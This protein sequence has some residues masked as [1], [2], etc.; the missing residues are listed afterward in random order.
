MRLRRGLTVIVTTIAIAG[1]VGASLTPTSATA[2][3]MTAAKST[4]VT[5]HDSTK[6]GNVR[7][8]GEV[9][10]AVQH[11]VAGA[12]S[13]ARLIGAHAAGASLSLNFGLPL[14]NMS[15]LNT[16]I[17]KE[18]KTHH[19]LTR[20]ALYRQ[21]AP[22]QAQL[23]ALRTWLTSHGYT[24]THVSRDRTSLAA[25]APTST[26]QRSLSTQISNY[27]RSGYTYQGVKVPAYSF[28]SNTT[29]PQVPAR[30]GV[31]SITGL[32]DIDQFFT[33][34]QLAKGAAAQGGPNGVNTRAGGGYYPEDVRAMYDV[35]GHG[36]DATGQTLGFTL[37]GAGETQPAMAQ[38][39][40]TTGDTPVTVD[41]ACVASGNSPSTPSSCTSVQPAANHLVSILE[42]GNTNGSQG[43]FEYAG[44]AETG[45]D[46]EQAH[47][48]ATGAAMK[49]YLSDCSNTVPV[50]S[51][52]TNATCNGSDV[53]MEEAV[54]D[55]ADDPTLHTVSNSWGYGGD[56][57]WGNNDPFKL[58]TENSFA[59]AAAAGTTFWFSTGDDGS[60][61]SGYPADSDYVVGVGG[62]SDYSTTAL[63][64]NTPAQV[65]TR[66]T[67]TTWAA[68]GSWC[69]SL[70]PRP[71]WQTGAAVT[72]K[73]PCPGRIV[74]DV[75]AIA[76]TNTSV[77]EAFT[78]GLT[79][80]TPT[81]RTGG[82][83]G[84]SVAAPEMNGMEA[85]TEAFLAQQT[86]PGGSTPAIGFEGP[87][88]Y[89]LGDS[90]HSSSY[91]NDVVCG[92][93]ANPS[94]GPD[95]DAASA[96]WDPA[97]GWGELDWFNYSTGY[98][99]ALGATGLTQPASIATNYAYG[100]AQTPTNASE[101]AVSLP[102]TSTGYSVGSPSGGTP[103]PATFLARN[104]WGATNN[105]LKT[106]DGG[107]TWQTTN[108]DMLAISCTPALRCIEVGDGGRIRRTTDGGV[109]WTYMIS[110]TDKALTSIACPNASIC[111]TAGD[112]GQV[113]KSTNGGVTWSFLTSADGNPIYGLACPSTTICYTVDSYA[114]VEKTL[115]GG[116]TWTLSST[117]ITT[118]GV[119]VPG[120]GGPNP[121]A[122][123]F[124]ITCTDINDCVAVGGF[125]A[126]GTDSPILV[127][128]NG[129]NTWTLETSNS[130]ASN[131]L[132]GVTCVESTCY[133]V[134]R[135]GAIV[136]STNG[137]ITWTAM[138]SNTTLELTGITCASATS[139]VATG[140]TGTIDVLSG[141]VWTP[142]TA[143]ANSNFLAAVTCLS[144]T[145]CVAAG[146][147]G[148]TLAFD[149][150]NVGG[151]ATLLAGGGT[152]QQM[153]GISCVNAADCVAVGAAGT[154]LTTSN[155]GQTWLPR[156]SGVTASLAGVSCV[157][158]VCEA[159]GAVASGVA[160]MVGS[161]DGGVTWS[162]QTSGSTTALTGIACTS[163][164]S[165]VAVGGSGK[166]LVTTNGGGVWTTTTSGTTANL[167]AVACPS[168]SSCYAVGA[169]LAPAT[170]AT[171]LASADGGNTWAA[172]TS[173]SPQGL[174]A[175]ACSS[176]SAC[177]AGGALG[178]VVT[179]V[180]GGNIWT[181]QGN[182][183]SGPTSAL[184]AGPTGITAIFAAA[185]T[186]ANCDLGTAS[187][188]DIMTTPLLTVTV[189]ATGAFGDTPPL[190]GLSPSDNSISYSPP[191]QASNVTGALTCSTTATPTSDPGSYPV[192]EC[193]GLSDPGFSVVYDLADSS[194]TVG[195]AD[196][197]IDFPPISTVTFGA[198]PF[199]PNAT[200]SSGLP[201]SFAATGDCDVNAGQVEI[202]GAGSCTVTA[203]QAGN[204][205]FNAAPDVQQSFDIAKADQTITFGSLDPK[206]FG[207]ASFQIDPTASSGLPVSVSA[208][209]SCTVDSATAPATVT[210]TGGGSCQ[211]SATQAGNDDYN[212]APEVDRSFDIAKAN[213]TIT[214]GALPDKTFNDAPFDLTATASSGDP[215]SYTTA[216]QCSVSGNTVTITGGGSCTITASQAGDS[217]YNPAPDVQQS[218]DIAKDSQNITF[219]QPADTTFGGADVTVS[220]TASSGLTV[221]FSVSGDCTISGTTVHPTGVGTCTVTA[222]QAG[223]SD[224]L[225]APTVQRTFTIAKGSQT[226]TFGAL[227][228]RQYGAAPFTVSATA[229]SG[230]TV[231][232]AAES[233]SSCTVS[234]TTV[235]VTG[236]GTCTIDASQAGDTNWNAATTVTQA[237]DVTKGSTTVTVTPASAH[238]SVGSQAYTVTVMGG[239]VVAPSGSASLKIGA[240]SCTIAA[241]SNAGTGS[242]SVTQHAGT[243]A[244]TAHYTGDS[245]YTASTGTGSVA[246]AKAT[247]T[248]S[249]SVTAGALSKGKRKL[250]VKVTVTGAAGILPHGTVAVADGK[251][252]RCSLT[253]SGVAG[254]CTLTGAPAGALTVTARY[255]GS[256][257]YNAATGHAAVSA[258]VARAATLAASRGLA[259]A[260]RI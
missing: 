232:F 202:T 228:N 11:A 189:N 70:E 109:T 96:G 47:G 59:I 17:N 253:V 93:T 108:S 122:G 52:L 76:D 133:A 256:S 118:P 72:A 43:N 234:G 48:M 172:Q 168:A 165:C 53:G 141:G 4:P 78:S 238:V 27:V 171:I 155:G 251:G 216:G 15:A 170:T 250:A 200:A 163:S 112:R 101:R 184:N 231:T 51:G 142:S 194:Y 247:P 73:A 117:P 193:S 7:L 3:P 223:D 115:D 30:L 233:G 213:Q 84:T 152:T 188:G 36:V 185:C 103:W 257:D 83:G 86:Y 178:T 125:E 123:L 89:Q 29:N 138:T 159:D 221:L 45:L 135:T 44:N 31:Q 61:E 38:F 79:A 85:V 5:W 18:A 212:A 197:T 240:K 187:A 19:Y 204:T 154:I 25:K 88:L 195:K 169:V 137:G 219:A 222:T 34:A 244:I 132:S 158:L 176:G 113:L 248:V 156:T 57:E 8:A 41:P 104:A 49:Y 111:Y 124:G 206:T 107:A 9:P 82:V 14:R 54:E 13:T 1:P 167:T 6:A 260:I 190:T 242:C 162:P 65:A 24:V 243:H 181:Q 92:N 160:V 196:Q 224:Y 254:H 209:G 81:V 143:Q 149:P 22:P 177:F 12:R 90:T 218:F 186:S 98:A 64:A 237:F 258:K 230:L 20:A 37:W 40:T 151:S 208:S 146:K 191:N 199:T 114:H 211:I 210:I 136:T 62:T 105:F 55:A 198:A 42:N 147:Q 80:G 39:A 150:T 148:A 179:T 235:T 23:N 226:I 66:S 227:A 205:D 161:S 134:G 130:G 28:Y 175:V 249:V 131:Y 246:V 99:I 214:F 180:D 166:T 33:Q 69:S 97:T 67:Q 110:H 26:V 245:N 173:N 75:S 207:D 32:A 2:A 119:D 153:N 56:T 182:P 174:T 252:Q 10:L 239:G 68:G 139:C 127:T 94:G 229:S 140:Q 71:A 16:L 60:F 215:V 116:N 145:E 157:G 183:I 192:S 87:E 259:N 91:F 220:G 225:P 95:G 203:S 100:C 241:L 74:P 144:A 58:T 255:A 126:T 164:T 50:G 236:I 21:F 217:N 35:S 46:I 201:V 102:T 77:F 129:G 106:T 120:S 121:F 63:P 128:S